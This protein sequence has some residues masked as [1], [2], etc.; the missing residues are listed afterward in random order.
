MK[1]LTPIGKLIDN[2]KPIDQLCYESAQRILDKAGYRYIYVTWSG[3]I[4]STLVLSEL[5]KIAPK[6]QLIV[7]MDNHSVLEYPEFYEKY[8]SGKLQTTPMDFYTDAPLEVAIMNGVVVTGHLIDP[9]F[10]SNNYQSMPEE[11]LSKNMVDFLP[12]LNRYSQDMYQKLINACPRTITN[13]KELFWWIDY[14]LNY[15]SE[16]LMWL[17]EVPDM[18]Y[19]KNL[20]HFGMGEDWNNYAVSTDVEIK[21]PGYE[22]KKFKQPLKDHL[23]QFTKDDYYTKEKIKMPS[24]RHYRTDEQ[25]ARKKANWIDTQWR[26]G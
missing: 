14:T 2:P 22:F 19:G 11:Q 20:L 13:V 16:E 5:L 3:G 18:I 26:R 7:M 23:Y 17:L 21:W 1:C 12:T 4:D 10:G 24:W 9:V 8:I 6:D 25:R 15:Q